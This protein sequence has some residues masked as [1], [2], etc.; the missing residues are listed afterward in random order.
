MLVASMRETRKRVGKN[1]RD[2]CVTVPML[3]QFNFRLPDAGTSDYVGLSFL[4]TIVWL[5]FYLLCFVEHFFTHACFVLR[6]SNFAKTY[7]QPRASERCD[8]IAT[9]APLNIKGFWRQRMYRALVLRRDVL[10][11]AIRGKFASELIF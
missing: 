8:C 6:L 7:V 1:S 10:L 9:F 11:N 4:C 3:R 5:V 2:V